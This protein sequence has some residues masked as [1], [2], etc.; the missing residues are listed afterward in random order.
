[1]V[2][3]KVDGS[4]HCGAI[5]FEAEVNPSE[6]GICHCT[7]CQSLTGSAFRVTVPA[8]AAAFRLTAGKPKTYLKVAD[9]GAR[10]VQAFCGDCGSPLYATSDEPNPATIGIRI[11]TIRQRSALR[12]ARQI[13]R[14]SALPWVPAMPHLATFARED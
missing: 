12:P 9:S 4:C 2:A 5:C 3:V 1:M 14:G 11:G 10:R 7:D 8:S 13:W 6:V